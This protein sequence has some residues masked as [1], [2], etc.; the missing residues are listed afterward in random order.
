MFGCCTS[1]LLRVFI[2]LS[3]ARYVCCA[4]TI[5]GTDPTGAKDSSKALNAYIR[6]LC[7]ED[8]P[9]NIDAHAVRAPRVV[10]V[11]L[12]SGIYRLD[13]PLIFDRNVS[14]T[15]PILVREGTL[16]AGTTLGFD[17]FLVEAVEYI[18]ER[19]VGMTLTFDR[20][21]FASNFTG[22][23]LLVNKSSFTTVSNCNFLNFAT[24]GIW[25]SGADF[26][27]DR[28][29]LMECTA[30]MTNCE[31]PQLKATAMYIKGADSHF[32]RNVVACT[33]I[34]FVNAD[35]D[36]M[37][38]QNHIWTNCHPP[39]D[40]T[41]VGDH[42]L[43]GFLVSGGTPQI[44]GGAID[45]C[46]LR[47]TSYRGV[48]ITNMHFNGVSKLVL[49]APTHAPQPPVATDTRCQYWRGAMC[50][51]RVT[52]NFFTCRGSDSSNHGAD[53]SCGTI[54]TNYTPTQAQQMDISNNA[55]E[56]STSAV[57][58]RATSCIGHSCTSLFGPCDNLHTST[59]RVWRENAEHASQLH[60][61][62]LSVLSL[63]GQQD[64]VAALAETGLSALERARVLTA[65]EHEI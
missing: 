37:Y 47:I 62:S 46:H 53:A 32:N 28:S 52:N 18:G 58:T 22:G 39:Q 6:Q 35:G 5:P 42:N 1:D 36:N 64:R 65:L 17:R 44:S 31:G 45:N 29:V 54:L 19:L 15:G 49:A 21:I 20:V 38:F 13:S 61:L 57:C 2:L 30:G 27:L 51:L 25:T 40:D 60:G 63:L 10:V 8:N 50:S 24:F 55:W 23:G 16:L 48:I 12:S 33:H 14:C 9:L 34:G 11:D 59:Q 41:G 3:A 43:L 56:N 4:A 26:R 7:A